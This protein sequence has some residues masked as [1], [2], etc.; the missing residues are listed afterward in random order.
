MNELD[1]NQLVADSLF[2]DLLVFLDS[3]RQSVDEYQT[4]YSAGNT[5]LLNVAQAIQ[6]DVITSTFS[7]KKVVCKKKTCRASVKNQVVD[8]PLIRENLLP[9]LKCC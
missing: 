6:Y 8:L 7:S 2:H 5:T 4:Q 1:S 9:L 3:Q